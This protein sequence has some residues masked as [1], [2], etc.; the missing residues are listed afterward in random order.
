MRGTAGYVKTNSLATFSD[1]LLHIDER[2]LADQQRF[3]YI[4][5]VQYTKC[6]LE[7]LLGGMNDRDGLQERESRNSVLPV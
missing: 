6:S 3:I 1:E 7:D 2:V 4:I 5:S